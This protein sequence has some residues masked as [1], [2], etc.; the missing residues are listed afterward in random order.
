MR[1]VKYITNL[2]KYILTLAIK[3]FVGLFAE[4]VLECHNAMYLFL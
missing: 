2:A 3:S 1:T 4:N